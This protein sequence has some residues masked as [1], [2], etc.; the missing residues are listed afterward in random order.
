[1][2]ISVEN[3]S[4]RFGATQA[5]D[6]ISLTFEEGKIYGL[7]GRN[8]AGKSTLLN[9]ISGRLYPDSGQVL[10]DGQPAWE[11][12][13]A[14]SRLYLMSEQTLYPEGMRVREAFHWS[15]L[16]YPQFDEEF[17]EK[18]ADSFGLKL[19]ARI[20]S[21]STGYLSIFKLVTAL[22]VN[23]PYL[24]LDEPVLGLDAN[25]RELFYKVL[26]AKYSEKPFTAVLSTHL[27]EE[28]AGFIEDAAI[29]K[30][31]K[32]LQA[33]PKEELLAGAYTVSGKAEAV[34]A[35]LKGRKVLDVDV[36]G[37]LRCAYVEGVPEREKAGE[38]LEFAA[39]D[40]QKLFILMTNS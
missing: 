7:L 8:G 35:Y 2:S 14:Q 4:K 33:C 29:I 11:N 23:V 30:E 1:M 31:G 28:A 21:L 32:L 40:L 9:I 18:L 25:H 13:S 34:E 26:L 27:I 6:S 12:D 38:G 22:S 20:K 16:F 3:V 5:L 39:M 10:C 19:S 36:I 17:A 15:K 37:G 24:L